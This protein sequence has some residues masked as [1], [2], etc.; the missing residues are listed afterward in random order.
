M[1]IDSWAGCV[2]EKRAHATAI[3]PNGGKVEIVGLHVC[4]SQI[5]EILLP[6]SATSA[7]LLRFERLDEAR[8]VPIAINRQPRADR[9]PL[10]ANHTLLNTFGAV[11][12]SFESHSPE[13]RADPC[14]LTRRAA[15]Q[16]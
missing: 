11:R 16:H 7:G 9:H 13:T 4:I 14:Q 6:K 3:K 12:R 8:A 5:C 10:R 1:G 2:G 15:G